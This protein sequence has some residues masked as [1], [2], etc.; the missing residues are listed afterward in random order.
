[1]SG[2]ARDVTDI[3][4]RAARTHRPD[5]HTGQGLGRG[6]RVIVGVWEHEDYEQA[7]ARTDKLVREQYGKSRGR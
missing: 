5:R 3:R 4:E 6:G 7:A 2:V 1:M